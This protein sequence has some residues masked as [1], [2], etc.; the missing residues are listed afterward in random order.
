MK[1]KII[2]D[3]PTTVDIDNLPIGAIFFV[4]DEPYMRIVEA[5]DNFGAEANSVSL[6][7]GTLMY[8]ENEDSEEY[9]IEYFPNYQNIKI[10]GD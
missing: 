6:C 7:G 8:W 5:K 10:V 2:F 1:R 9:K 3:K 4:D